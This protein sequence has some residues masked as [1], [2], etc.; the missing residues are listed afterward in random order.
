MKNRILSE[1][2]FWTHLIFL[3]IWFIPFFIPLTV[4]PERV[5]YHLG[6]MVFIWIVEIMWGIV[7]MYSLG[8]WKLVCPWTSLTQYFRGYEFKDRRN[9]NHSFVREFARKFNLQI[10]IQFVNGVMLAT[11]II[12]IIQFFS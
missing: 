12:V 4:W 9:Y 8:Y 7:Y 2:F 5:L 10:S 1:F 6:F 3:G 11:F